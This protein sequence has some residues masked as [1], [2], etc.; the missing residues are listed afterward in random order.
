MLFVMLAG[1]LL[2]APPPASVHSNGGKDIPVYRRLQP[3]E[4]R[5]EGLLR[6]ITCPGKGPVTLV[7]K[8]KD[9]VV[10]YTAPQLTSVDFIVYRKDFKGPV[11]CEGFGDGMPVYVTWKPDGKARRAIAIEFLP[12]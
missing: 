2:Q 12:K 4:E 9:A 7:V 10:L 1:L 6:R 8:Q 11:G 5:A 3:G